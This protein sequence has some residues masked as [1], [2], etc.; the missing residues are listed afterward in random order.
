[1]KKE[2]IEKIK[3]MNPVRD[4]ISEHTSV[5]GSN[6]AICPFH[7]DG[8]PSLSISSEKEVWHCF[9]CLKSGDVFTF[10]QEINHCSFLDAVKLLAKRARYTIP[11]STPEEDQKMEAENKIQ[12]VRRAAVDFYHRRLMEIP[13]IRDHLRERGLTDA[14]IEKHQIGFADGGLTQYLTEQL[15]FLADICIE[16]GVLRRNTRDQLTD[17]FNDR[18]VLPNWRG[19][20]IVHI[21]GRT[22]HADTRE[23]PKYRHIPGNMEIWGLDSAKNKDEVVIV[24]GIFDALSLHLWDIPAVALVGV[25]LKDEDVSKFERFKRVYVCLDGD[26]T[27]RSKA[28]EVARRIGVKA[29]VVDLPDG[30][31]VNEFYLGGAT[32]TEFVNRMEA[33]KPYIYKMIDEVPRNMDKIELKGALRIVLEEIS[34]CDDTGIEQFLDSLKERFGLKHETLRAY[35]KEIKSIRKT[36]LDASG[37]NAEEQPLWEDRRGFSPAQDFVDGQAFFTVTVPIANR[38][39]SKPLVIT[40]SHDYFEL[41]SEELIRRKLFSDIPDLYSGSRTRWS[42]SKEN[43]FSVKNYLDNKALTVDPVALFNEIRDV[44]NTHIDFSN[45][46]YS[47]LLAIWIMGTYLHRMFPCYPYIFLSGHKRSGKTLTME[48]T[49]QLAFNG[50][51]A[52]SLSGA[53]IYRQIEASRGAILIDE[54]EKYKNRSVGDDSD[55]FSIVNSGYKRSGNVDRCVGDNHDVKSFSTYSPKMFANTETLNDIL[56]DRSIIIRMYRTMRKMPPFIPSQ[57]ENQFQGLRDKLYVF[58]MSSHQAILSEFNGIPFGE[59]KNREFELWRPMLAIA[60]FIDTMTNA[61]P[62]LEQAL[63]VLAKESREQKEDEDQDVYDIQLAT[64]IYDYFAEQFNKRG[65]ECEEIRVSQADVLGRLRLLPQFA[66]TTKN[67]LTRK[68]KSFGFIMNSGD[69]ERSKSNSGRTTFYIIRRS[70]LAQVKE[71]YFSRLDEQGGEEP[72]DVILDFY[73]TEADS[74]MELAEIEL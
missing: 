12:E 68:L 29:K 60:H 72:R 22:I 50:K 20:D 64:E 30:V 2:T 74:E 69:I 40:S 26:E 16:S 23:N 56:N 73:E 49:E 36:N 67:S 44:F 24:E 71:R 14:L 52:A 55:L 39:A 10:V 28:I 46:S 57:M 17:W 13:S 15:S 37:D 3:N 59:L 63:N 61:T 31:D 27:G 41:T 58:A 62:A 19:R 4:V 9:G 25:H 51:L 1:M 42:L 11:F 21:T 33:A 32:K 48:I 43:P 70:R 34:K 35:R 7:N 53:S 65:V 5:N 54:S 38:M 6:M 66:K 47:T 18:I 8:T 45:T